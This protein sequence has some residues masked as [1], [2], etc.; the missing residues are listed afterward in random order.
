MA[1]NGSIHS[2]WKVRTQP[3]TLLRRHVYNVFATKIKPIRTSR[4]SNIGFRGFVHVNEATAFRSVPYN[5]LPPPHP[6]AVEDL[7]GT[8][9]Y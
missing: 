1:I 4:L 9:L 6:G 7:P 3:L 8:A 5:L 2:P